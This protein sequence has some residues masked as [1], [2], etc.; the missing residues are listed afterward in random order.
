[1][2]STCLLLLVFAACSCEDDATTS[3]TTSNGPNGNKE[4]VQKT[5]PIS[6][7]TGIDKLQGFHKTY[8]DLYDAEAKKEKPDLTHVR[9]VI[10]ACDIL[11]IALELSIQLETK[12]TARLR[13]GRMRQELD[14]LNEQ[15]VLAS[16]E[17]GEI[18]NV[19][20]EDAKG[21]SPI[22]AGLTRAELEDKLSDIREQ[23]RALG[24]QLNEHKATMA[25]LENA[26]NSDQAL[27]PGD[28]MATRELAAVKALKQK[29]EALR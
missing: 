25:K 10:S 24:T 23:Q 4:P 13:H 21:T 15:Q 18:Q 29:A 27:A 3:G 6:P 5:D 8:A 16:R 28:T 9:Q 14:K 12:Q 11:I 19:L 20:D 7:T 1:M 26:L 17:A 22:P 2:R